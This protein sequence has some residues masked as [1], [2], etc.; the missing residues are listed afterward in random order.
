[1][2][3]GGR[4]RPAEPWRVGLEVLTDGLGPVGR[5]SQERGADA[6]ALTG[7]AEVLTG[8]LR[9]FLFKSA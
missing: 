5:A 7:C 3:G 1:M 9:M 4:P 2:P 6:Q 8:R